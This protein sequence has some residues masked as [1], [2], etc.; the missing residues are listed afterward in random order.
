MELRL[1]TGSV[2]V[3]Y[4]TGKTFDHF[5]G[6]QWI[7]EYESSLNDSLLDSL[8]T[9]CSVEAFAGENFSD[10]I[11]YGQLG[12]KLL[13][14]HTRHIFSPCKYTKIKNGPNNIGLK[15][16][17]GDI[18]FDKR[19]SRNYEYLVDYMRLNSD[20]PIFD[21]L[22]NAPGSFT[23]SD[24]DKA[25][26]LLGISGAEGASYRDLNA[27]RSGIYSA[28]LPKVSLS[29][30]LSSYM[31]ELL[32]DCDTDIEKLNRIEE[33]LS[34]MEYSSSSDGM[35]ND[36]DSE[37]KFADYFLFHRQRG[38][39]VCYAT[40]F[41]TLSRSI[42][43]PAR[44]VQGYR[45][46]IS[47]NTPST[48]VTENMSHA[49]PECYIEGLGWVAFEPTPGYKVYRGWKTAS[50]VSYEKAAYQAVEPEHIER[51][52]IDIEALSVE[53]TD[54]T[55][56]VDVRAVII[57]IAVALSVSAILFAITLLFNSLRYRFS[58][59]EKKFRIMF[60]KN[61]T[62]MEILGLKRAYNETLKEFLDKA[63]LIVPDEL[64]SFIK[65]YEKYIYTESILTDDDITFIEQSNR[66][67]LRF[68]KAQGIK[69]RLYMIRY[70]F[71]VTSS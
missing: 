57:I 33:M 14:M 1:K 28:Y 52:E 6:S 59:K 10:Y 61:M 29:P 19:R 69:Y 46:P 9:Y 20:N 17:D 43:I 65:R 49:W 31:D 44:Y 8:E 16:K 12:L 22:A 67:L 3:V 13:N 32:K 35:P 45:V 39:C 42:G 66:D 48:I 51:P 58:G 70:Y 62:L 23:Q 50:E 21:D 15:F 41:V 60:R 56:E 7:K 64:L 18:F 25:M 55:N 11:K 38:N 27:Y 68:I 47:K 4:L 40:V 53:E 2:P 30:E 36:I 26:S 5:D 71:M 54:P 24:W 63:S 37:A 34:T